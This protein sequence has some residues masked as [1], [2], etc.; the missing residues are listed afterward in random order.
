LKKGKHEK[1][2][3]GKQTNACFCGSNYE[4]NNLHVA[5]SSS[6]H[7]AQ[8]STKLPLTPLSL[9][10]SSR[11]VIGKKKNMKNSKTRRKKCPMQ[12]NYFL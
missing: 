9:I 3:G 11:L 7:L 2:G 4:A 10:W 8:V 5:Y 1:N 12:E 6:R